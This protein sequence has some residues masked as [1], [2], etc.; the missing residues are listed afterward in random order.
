MAE[1]FKESNSTLAMLKTKLTRLEEGRVTTRQF[2]KCLMNS[3]NLLRMLNGTS[4]RLAECQA[5]LN[6]TEERNSAFVFQLGS[7]RKS[8]ESVSAGIQSVD[9]RVISLRA[10]LEQNQQKLESYLSVIANMTSTLLVSNSLV[11]SSFVPDLPAPTPCFPPNGIDSGSGH[12][13]TTSLV[14]L[15]SVCLNVVLGFVCISLIATLCKLQCKYP[16]FLPRCTRFKSAGTP[17]GNVTPSSGG[18]ND[19]TGGSAKQTT[20]RDPTSRSGSPKREPSDKKKEEEAPGGGTPNTSG[21]GGSSLGAIGGA[22]GA[23]KAKPTGGT[24]PAP[25]DADAA[26]RKDAVQ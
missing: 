13:A 17:G 18:G 23:E 8:L 2:Q 9:Q 6:Q 19:S 14:A 1:L 11:N 25:A 12:D 4:L 3:T 16:E 21:T 10:M 7:F 22:T 20:K 24:T 15:A 5:I 26:A